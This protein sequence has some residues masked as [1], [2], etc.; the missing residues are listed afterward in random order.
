MQARRA[1]PT[2]IHVWSLG[3]GGCTNHEQTGRACS[4]GG[5]LEVARV[6]PRAISHVLDVG[7]LGKEVFVQHEQRVDRLVNA[8]GAN[9]VAS[10]G[11]GRADVRLVTET[12]KAVLDGLELHHIADLATGDGRCACE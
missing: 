9:R 3:K 8:G 5:E 11:L 1:L 7:G 2:C 4:G 12:A 6:L 10:Q